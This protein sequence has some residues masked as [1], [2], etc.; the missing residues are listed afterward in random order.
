MK[1]A[2]KHHVADQAAQDSALR[3]ALRGALPVSSGEDTHG[4]RQ[5]ILAQWGQRTPVHVVNQHGSVAALLHSMRAHR[6]QWLAAC[7][8]VILAIG[9]QAQRMATERAMDELLEPDVLSLIAMGEL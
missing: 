1:P 2:I 6:W 4:L 3:Q 5:R 7:L 9:F 8:V